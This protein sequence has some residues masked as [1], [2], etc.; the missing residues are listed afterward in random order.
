MPMKITLITPPDIFENGNDSILF[1][2]ITDEEQDA[3]SKWLGN[4]EL[5][6]PVNIYFYQGEPNIPWLLHALSCTNFKYINLNNMSAVSTYMAGYVLSKSGVY[7]K[8]NDENVA[9][10]YSHINSGRVDG[11]DKFLERI[12]GGKEQDRSV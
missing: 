5:D 9:A 12:F 11:T 8:T 1:M 6:I 2:D 4:K 10:L 7:Y 3:V